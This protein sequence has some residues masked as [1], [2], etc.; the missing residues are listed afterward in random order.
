MSSERAAGAILD[1]CRRGDAELTM[2]APARAAALVHGLMP[3]VTADLLGLVNRLLPGPGG[4]G[5]GR[6]K[7]HQSE[8]L[9][10][11]SALTALGEAAARRNNQVA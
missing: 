4:V 6:R 5:K 10:S 11:P 7:G 8:S 1:A 2:P 3:G 9:V